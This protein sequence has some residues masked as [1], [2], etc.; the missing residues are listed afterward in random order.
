MIERVF[1][2]LSQQNQII[3][4]LNLLSPQPAL[5]DKITKP[6]GATQGGT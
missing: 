3:H 6:Q 1:T 5:N 2:H 4:T